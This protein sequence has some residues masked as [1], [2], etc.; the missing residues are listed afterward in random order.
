MCQ[1]C[2]KTENLNYR[3][4]L[5]VNFQLNSRTNLNKLN[6]STLCFI[7]AND[8]RYKK[9]NLN[10]KLRQRFLKGNFTYL[11]LGSLRPLTLPTVNFGTDL[12]VLKKIIEENNFTCQ[13]IKSAQKPVLIVSNEFFKRTGAINSLKMLQSCK[14]SHL[15]TLNWNHINFLQSNLS[16]VG[17]QSIANLLPIQNKDFHE[18]SSFYSVC[19]TGQ[20]VPNLK[21]NCGNKTFKL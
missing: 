20:K 12:N 18:F 10:L 1:L 7:F 9:Y 13:D 14:N 3:T 5:E 2:Y 21:T 11:P 4:D 8:T 6:K 15:I 16:E 17:I 19:I